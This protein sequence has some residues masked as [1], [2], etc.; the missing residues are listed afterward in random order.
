MCHLHYYTFCTHVTLFSLMLHLNCTVLSQLGSSNF[1]INIIRVLN[2]SR[3]FPITH[4]PHYLL[5]S[6]H[7]GLHSDSMFLFIKLFL[8]NFSM[9]Y[10]Y[11]SLLSRN[12]SQ[13]AGPLV[14]VLTWWYTALSL[15]S[16]VKVHGI[17]LIS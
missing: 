13:V 16:G 11:L 14:L 2:L 15:S 10:Y 8:N 6:S 4:S 1:F 5:P 12:I 9:C 7:P 17:T 3:P